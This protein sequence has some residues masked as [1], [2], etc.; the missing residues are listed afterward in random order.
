MTVSAPVRFRPVPPAFR[1]MRRTGMAASRLNRSQRPA[2][3]GVEP[4]MRSPGDFAGVEFGGEEVEL[5]GE[6]RKH[7][8]AVAAVDGLVEELE[9]GGELGGGETVGSEAFREEAGVAAEL[10]EAEQVGQGGEAQGAFSGT[11]FLELG[12]LLLA[13]LAQGEVGGAG[14]GVEAA[15]QDLLDAFGEFGGDGLL[16]AAQEEGGG[17]LHEGAG[18]L[19]AFLGAGACGRRREEAGHE[20]TEE[21]EQVVDGVFH[22]RA[23]EQEAGAAAEGGEGPGVAGGAVFDMLGLVAE[24]AAPL[25]FGE[26][27]RVAGEGGVGGDDEVVAGEGGGVFGAGIAVVDEDAQVAG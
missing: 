7:E 9:E 13:A 15:G 25:D 18:Q 1:E 22:G 17:A 5:A 4:S 16:G 20:E 10:A 26:Q 2:R 8:H 11:G 6:L 24:D 3:S 19:G 14:V 12:K 23:G 27:V 21:G